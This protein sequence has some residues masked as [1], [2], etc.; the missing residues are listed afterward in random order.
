MAAADIGA[1]IELDN[2][3]VTG[4]KGTSASNGLTQGGRVEVGIGAKSGDSVFV[5]AKTAFV[6]KKDGSLATDDMWV[7]L[8]NAGGDVKLGRFEGANLFPLQG[9]TVVEHAGNVYTAGTLRG[10]V[11]AG[12]F[13]AAGTL[14]LGVGALEVGYVDG[15]KDTVTAVGAKGLRAVLSLANGPLSAAVGFESGEYAAAEGVTAEK[16]KGWGV[17]T[18]YDAGAFKIVGNYAL[19]QTKAA[20][21][22]RQSALGLSVTVGSLAVGLVN[23]VTDKKGGDDTVQTVYASYSMPL[24]GVKGASVTPALSRSTTKD[25]ITGNSLDVNAV[26]VRLNYGF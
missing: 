13:H 1:N 10:R 21:D 25:S 4:S 7:Q 20:S 2:T 11:G 9:D 19:G 8:G 15:S 16:V 24:L 22:N 12:G 26:R 18:G 17:T 14:N 3:V 5:A 6:S 23:A